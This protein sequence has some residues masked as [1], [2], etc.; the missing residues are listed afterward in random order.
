MSYQSTFR[1]DD[2]DKE[3]FR[4]EPSHDANSSGSLET[5]SWDRNVINAEDESGGK[6]K[7]FILLI[8][9]ILLLI[10]G[11]FYFHQNTT[12]SDKKQQININK[13]QEHEDSLT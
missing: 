13:D 4:S 12:E 1:D 6:N 2:E 10:G 3:H 8:V 11:T 5:V 7:L 9:L